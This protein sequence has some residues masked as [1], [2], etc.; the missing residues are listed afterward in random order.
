MPVS[1]TV[2][3]PVCAASGGGLRWIGQRS[4][5]AGSAGP[6]S[7]GTPSHVEQ[8]AQHRIADRDGERAADC[9]HRGAAP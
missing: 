3:V 2:L 5:A 6:R 8:A 9:T 7:P 1:N 4:V